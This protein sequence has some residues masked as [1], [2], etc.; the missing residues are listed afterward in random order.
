M[1]ET[2]T[3]SALTRWR[4]D[5]ISFIEHV[6]CDPE[7]SE[8]FAL[9][10]AE[11]WFL[12]FAFT[13]NDNGRLKYPELVFGAIKKSGKTT[14]AALVMITMILLFGGRFAEGYCVANDFEQAQSR[15]FAMARRIV[16]AS[17]L[18][19]SEA[20]ITA[21]KIVFTA[22]NATIQAIGSDY[23]SA[24]GANPTIVCFD[25][26][27]GYVSERSRRLWDEMVTS[28]A[29][30]ISA[31]LVVSY[32]GFTG[33]SLLLEELHKRGMSL[34]EV[35]PSLHAGDGLL[36]AWHTAPIASWQTSEWVEEMRRTM[37]P[38]AFARQMLNEFVSS[39]STFIDLS[40]WDAC[41]VLPAPP[42]E[43]QPIWI[44]VDASVKRDSTALVAVSY[45][46]KSKCAVLVAHRIFTPTPG[47]PID[48]EATVEQTIREWKKRF[49]V[50]CVYFDPYQM[51]ATAQ[52]LKKAGIKIEEF[53]QSLPNLTAA[54]SNLFD[55]ISERRLALYPAADIRLAVS[56]VVLSESSRGW[57]LSKEKQSF[58]IDVVVALSLAC[59]AAVRGDGSSYC[60][61]GFVGMGEE[62]VKPTPIPG[63]K[64]A[65]FESEAAAEL[66]KVRQRAQFGPTV[67][68]PWDGHTW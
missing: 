66:Y 12:K 40:A 17:P 58:K 36:F 38:S 6:L 21:D 41:T 8:P 50:R 57:K 25:E 19:K 44:G 2:L 1:A 45:S 31:R 43:R 20:R 52:R 60:L 42:I 7:T 49:F 5:P 64:R 30:R 32:A 33:E 23:A 51:V 53:P 16:E 46:Q 62:E 37:R 11:R 63:W 61:D 28:P 47:D 54:T 15:V 26:L 65:G 24:A 55:L 3:A 48:F 18:L 35:G 13:L 39:E 14:L 27:W 68:F 67:Q 34:P 9:S 4:A 29:R 22:L 59:L 56:R 10:E